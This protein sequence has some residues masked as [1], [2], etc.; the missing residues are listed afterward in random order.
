MASIRTNAGMQR[1]L[2]GNVDLLTDT[3][4][5]VL[6]GS[7]YT[8]NKDHE[9]ISDL[10]ANE[11]TGT[12]YT[13]GFAGSGRKTLASK[14]VTKDNSADIAYFD[15]NDLTWTAI[16]AG[17]AAY[18]AIVKE[19]TS[20]ADSPVLAIIDLSPDIA[21]NGGDLTVQWAATGLFKLS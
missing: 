13:S 18:A 8:P 6:L 10:G 1:I 7:G 20:D 14:A 2:N 19:V 11:L 17:T 16:N 12:G 9:F 5:V 4:K 15:A 21:T 3:L